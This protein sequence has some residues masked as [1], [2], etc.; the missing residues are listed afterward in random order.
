MEHSH[1][2]RAAV[3][4]VLGIIAV[5][6]ISLSFPPSENPIQGVLLPDK[7]LRSPSSPSDIKFYTD[8]PLT[9]VSLGNLHIARHLSSDPT[10]AD[11]QAIRDKATELA[12]QYGAN[13]II[14]QSEGIAGGEPFRALILNAKAIYVPKGAL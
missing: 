7:V 13:G 9:G 11:L 1:W 6:L 12:A 2:S 8:M 10:Q 5:F 14:V 4:G 3:G